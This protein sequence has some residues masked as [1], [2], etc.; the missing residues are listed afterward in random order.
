MRNIIN[1]MPSNVL[2]LVTS[3]V[4]KYGW[5]N[6][7]LSDDVLQ[8]KRVFPPYVFRAASRE[9]TARGK[10]ANDS[11]YFAV[12]QLLNKFERPP[13]PMRRTFEQTHLGRDFELSRCA[14]RFSGR[15]EGHL[16]SFR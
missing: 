5:D 4:S 12:Q 16:P 15:L 13:I 3:H 8:N 1:L 2:G 9:W 10:V 6:C 11:M 14:C 7:A